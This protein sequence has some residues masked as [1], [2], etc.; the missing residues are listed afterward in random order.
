LI[1]FFKYIKPLWYFNLAPKSANVP[2]WYEVPENL[3]HLVDKKALYRSDKA[4]KMDLAYQL[5]SAGYIPSSS[6]EQLDYSQTKITVKEN[7]ILLARFVK[8]QWLFIVCFFRLMELKNPILEIMGLWNALS[9]QKVK[10]KPLKD[11]LKE[12]Q[13]QNWNTFDSLLIKKNPLVSV[14][15]PTLNRYKYLKDVFRDLEKQT[16]KNFEVIVVDQTD[17]FDAKVYNGWTLNLRFWKQDE[18]ALW[19]AR[20]SAIQAAKGEFILFSEDD[21]RFDADFIQNHLKCID[22]FNSD[23]SNGVFFPEHQTIPESRNYFKFSEQFATGNA[24]IKKSVFM[25]LGLFDRQFEGQRMGDGEFGLRL[26]LTGYKC[27]SNPKAFCID[28]KAPEGGLRQMGSWDAW[29]PK[30]LTAPRPVPS[31]LYLSRKYFGRRSS[32]W[33][34]LLNVPSTFVPYKFKG[35]NKM[36]L[37]YTP[38]LTLLLPILLV[39][40]CKSW[41]LASKKINKGALIG[42]FETN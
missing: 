15:I 5:W 40:V 31:V 16:Y 30:G 33:E 28:I 4:L 2:Y 36:K 1:P 34:I 42:R 12:Q 22:Y 11:F 38:V 27:I 17:A 23:V 21:V 10:D 25:Q 19:L 37:I 41:Y 3:E 20:N 6:E 8:K 35:N 26:Y 39:T 29:R 7:Y 9:I 13:E 14:I 24:I 18:K 32:V